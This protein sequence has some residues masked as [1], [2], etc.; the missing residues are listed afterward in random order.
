MTSKVALLLLTVSFFFLTLTAAFSTT[1][2]TTSTTI[3][4]TNTKT[5]SSSAFINQQS[6]QPRRS[7]VL[8]STAPSSTSEA[9]ASSSKNK[10]QQQRPDVI[11]LKSNNI[12]EQILNRIRTDSSKLGKEY[13]ET[14]GLD[15][16]EEEVEQYTSAGL[17]AVLDSIKTTLQPI[18]GLGLS[19][20]PFLLRKNELESSMM[21]E[22]EI[23]LFDGFYTM[24]DLKQALID[25]FL[26]ASRGSTDNRK[27]WSIQPVSTPTGDS[28]EEARMTYD[29]VLIALE[30]GTVIFNAFGAHVPKLAGPCLAVTDATDT[31]NAVNL[32]VTSYGKKT[33]APPHTDKQDVIVIQTNGCKRWRVYKPPSSTIKPMSDVFARGK[34]I[35]NLPLHVLEEEENNANGGSDDKNLLLETELNPGDVLFIPAGFPHTTSTTG[36][37]NEDDDD[38]DSDGDKTSV[39]LTFNIDTRVWELDYLNARRLALRRANIIDKALG[40]SRDEDNVYIGRVNE[41]PKEIHTDLLKEFPLGFL[42]DNGEDASLSSV[43]TVTTELKR[44]AHAVDE[45]TFNSVEESIWKETIEKLKQEGQEYLDIHRD[46]YIAAIEEGRTRKAER[47]MKAHLNSDTDDNQSNKKVQ[48]TPDQIQRLSLFRVQKYYEKIKTVKTDLLKWS[49]E[50]SD[51]KTAPQQALPDNWA[52]VMPIR[53]NDEVEADLGGAFFPA[54]ITKVL[55]NGLYDVK[56]FDGDVEDGMERN[57]IKLLKPPSTADTTGNGDNND[58]DD[59]GIDTSNMTPKQL[60]RWKK[61]QQ[62]KN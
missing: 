11:T 40:Q 50:A 55:T 21:I 62:K 1:T 23:L 6:C 2:T 28:F 32:Y 43:D 19:G 41:L 38:N 24:K 18:D 61:A 3:T 13:A 8:F 45:D 10:N 57:L 17:Y 53:V 22:E 25:D 31:P 14:F 39:H 33:S 52:Y 42:N 7:V 51:K 35:D 49:Y 54:T 15:E 47:T 5:T 20:H 58:G 4:N 36:F 44:I 37:N 46:M 56:F 26:D 59:D 12:S 34:G 27:G 29:D 16:D 9:A 48:L 60:K 30:K